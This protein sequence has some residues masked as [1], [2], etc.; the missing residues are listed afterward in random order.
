MAVQSYAS[1]W[2]AAEAW[3]VFEED[4]R[5]HCDGLIASGSVQE[6]TILEGLRAMV[7]LALTER[8]GLRDRVYEPTDA[9]YLRSVH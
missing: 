7:R 2:E 4:D 6:D 5:A 8:F 9:Q 1:I 3:S